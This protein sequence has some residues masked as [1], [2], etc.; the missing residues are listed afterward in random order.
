MCPISY[1]GKRGKETG[2]GVVEGAGI[3][4][5]GIGD[6][7]DRTYRKIGPIRHIRPIGQIGPIGRFEM[8]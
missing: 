5:R 4:K 7:G 2:K 3:R 8:Q 6:G 1:H